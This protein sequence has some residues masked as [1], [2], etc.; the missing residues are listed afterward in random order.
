MK[1][2]W[3][4]WYIIDLFSGSDSNEGVFSALLYGLYVFNSYNNCFKRFGVAKIAAT[5]EPNN[6]VKAT[7]S[8]ANSL[9]KKFCPVTFLP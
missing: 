9:S 8:A 1:I 2:F 5:D 4:L 6:T 7:H 3:K